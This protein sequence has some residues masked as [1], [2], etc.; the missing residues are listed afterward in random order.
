MARESAIRES[1]E[2]LYPEMLK[3]VF[4]NNLLSVM[5]YGSYVSG[6]FIRGVSD[7]NILV[8]L[9]KPSVDQIKSLGG[10]KIH[11]VM[12]RH[13]ITPLILTRSEFI[14]SADVFPM[15]Y[16]DIRDRCRVLFGEDATRSLSLEKRNL[17]HQLEERLRGSVASL[18]QTLIA[19]RGRRRALEN[20]LKRF[21]GSL[22][23]LFRGMLLLKE[24]KEIP[25]EGPAIVDEISRAYG[26]EAAPFHELLQLRSGLRK[27]VYGVA[28]GVL[29]SL[30]E[31]IAQI[32]KMKFKE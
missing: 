9:D 3:D 19:S 14:N 29:A 18:R 8:L 16:A 31:L 11:T 27:D 22:K 21:F 2:E 30:E 17:R 20:N 12:R 1:V 4:G 32:D 25:Y 26:I 13:R 28:K 24:L 5:L 6:D 15:E 7:V 10:R 23:A